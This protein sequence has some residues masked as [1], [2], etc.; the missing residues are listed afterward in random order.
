LFRLAG[1]LHFRE[2]RDEVPQRHGLI[3]QDCIVG[4]EQ[5]EDQCVEFGLAQDRPAECAEGVLLEADAVPKP[6]V[7]A[8][9]RDNAFDGP[10]VE[11]YA[12]VVGRVCPRSEE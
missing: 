12:V 11:R 7:A 9:E 3:D 10:G 2:A 6:S 1:Q 8:S 4:K 5:G